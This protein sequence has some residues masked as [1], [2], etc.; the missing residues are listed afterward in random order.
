MKEVV[1][2]LLGKVIV[3]CQAYEDTPLFGSENMKKMAASAVLG[4]AQAFRAC[5][6]SDIK[7]I[8]SLG[9]YPIVGINKVFYP[10]RTDEYIFITPTFESAK[11]LIE[12][13]GCEVVALDCTIRPFRPKEE[14][15]ELLKK[16]NKHYPEIAIMADCSTYEECEFAES[17]GYVDILATT[18]SMKYKKDKGPDVELVRKIKQNLK[19][20]VNAEGEVWEEQDI[21]NLVEAGADMITIGSAITRP[22]NITE[23]FV[24]ANHKARE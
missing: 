24:K 4:G 2:Q 19:L 18:L 11:E 8:K 14:L 10:E 6:V 7:A 21:A 20:P 22:Q 13:A 3:S 15:L 9:S 17:T 12:E 23:R 1:K 5:W 16:I